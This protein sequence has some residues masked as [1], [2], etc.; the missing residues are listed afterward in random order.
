MCT[1]FA[2]ICGHKRKIELRV[3]VDL[4]PRTSL[5]RREVNIKLKHQDKETVFVRA[6]ALTLFLVFPAPRTQ[7]RP[8]I[9]ICWI[10]TSVATLYLYPEVRDSCK[11]WGSE[12]FFFFLADSVVSFNSHN[13]MRY[14]FILQMGKGKLENIR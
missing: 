2:L 8:L 9:S 3:K 1:L 5:L 10:S 11:F 4:I 7:S 6:K 12:I 14:F 13:I